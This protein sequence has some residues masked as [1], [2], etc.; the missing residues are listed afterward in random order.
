MITA[1]D[2]RLFERRLFLTAA[3]L[4]PAIVVLGFARTYYL[5]AYF[6]APATSSVLVHLHG[7]VMT[8]WVALFVT[9]IWLISRTRVRLHQQLGYLGIG[10]AALV[11]G[12][13]VPTALHAGKFGSASSPP[14]V[15][16]LA[17]MIVPMFD[18]LMFALFFGAAIYFRRQPATHKRLMLLTAINFVP[19]AIA[20]IPVTELQALGPLWFFG[21]PAALAILCVGL[22]TWRQHRLNPVFAIGA[23]LLIASYVTRLALMGTGTWMSVATWLTSFV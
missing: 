19:P 3:V 14:G 10:L 18:L 17:F 23:V 15:P 8:A 5:R 2:R 9:Q 1:T 11:I 7:L 20:R 22:D 6:A 16:P 21:F 13:G 4:F 12:I